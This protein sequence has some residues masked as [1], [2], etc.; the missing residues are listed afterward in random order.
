MQSVCVQNLKCIA[1][2][3]QNNDVLVLW[4]HW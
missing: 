1:S 3:F 4:R 2:P